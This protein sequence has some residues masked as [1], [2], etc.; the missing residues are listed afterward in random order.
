MT[1]I[2]NQHPYH[3][4]QTIFSSPVQSQTDNQSPIKLNMTCILS[5]APVLGLVSKVGSFVG[6]WR[7]TAAKP[8]LKEWLDGMK[9]K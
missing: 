4:L 1:N 6:A 2:G 7:T 8:G 5:A 3:I 9:K